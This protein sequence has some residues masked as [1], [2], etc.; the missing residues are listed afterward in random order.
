M[1]KIAFLQRILFV[2]KHKQRQQKE[3]QKKTTT[4][5]LTIF[6]SGNHIESNFIRNQLN[7]CLQKNTANYILCVQ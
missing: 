3:H 7:F 1:E 2:N 5:T 6:R 4:T